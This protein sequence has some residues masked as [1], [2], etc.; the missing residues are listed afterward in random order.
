MRVLCT[1]SRNFIPV[2]SL[3]LF[4]F[5]DR[6]SRRIII[7]S[8][9][10][11]WLLKFL[12]LHPNFPILLYEYINLKHRVASL[13]GHG[14]MKQEKGRKEGE[15]GKSNG[16]QCSRESTP[17]MRQR[18]HSRGHTEQSES[19]IYNSIPKG[20]ERSTGALNMTAVFVSPG[21]ALSWFVVLAISVI[22]RNAVIGIRVEAPQICTGRPFRFHGLEFFSFGRSGCAMQLLYGEHITLVNH[23]CQIA[24]GAC[25]Y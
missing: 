16:E 14:E 2:F 11:R 5:L 18:P 25:F 4:H 1:L 8:L 24:P 21:V 22:N 23:E 7:P 17:E 19:N 9:S 20:S 3:V 13:H 12:P 6:P 15:E 10:E